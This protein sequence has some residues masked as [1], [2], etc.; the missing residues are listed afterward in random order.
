MKYTAKEI[1]FCYY[2]I[3]WAFLEFANLTSIIPNYTTDSLNFQV[4]GKPTLYVYYEKS[5]SM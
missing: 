5:K 4:V 1:C 2:T 3:F